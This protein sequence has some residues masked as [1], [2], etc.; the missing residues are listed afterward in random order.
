MRERCVT[1]K[2]RSIPDSWD[3]PDYRTTGALVEAF[4]GLEDLILVSL[5][6][7][8]ETDGTASLLIGKQITSYGEDRMHWLT[9]RT[10]MNEKLAVFLA[11][12]TFGVAP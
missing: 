5:N 11:S 6:I 2:P 1:N 7:W 9:E 8:K 10:L 4:E 3:I 12:D